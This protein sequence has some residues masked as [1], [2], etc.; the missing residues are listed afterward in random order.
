[1]KSF[2]KK[3]NYLLKRT[4][5]VILLCC[6]VLLAAVS[7]ILLLS[8]GQTTETVGT[9]YTPPAAG[10]ETAG[11]FTTAPVQTPP[12][13]AGTPFPQQTEGIQTSGPS[14]TPP[15][16]APEETQIAPTAVPASPTVPPQNSENFDYSVLNGKDTT[17]NYLYLSPDSGFAVPAQAAAWMEQYRFIAK[18]NPTEKTVYLTFNIDVEYGFT[19]YLLDQLKAEGIKATFFASGDY[20]ADPDNAEIIKRIISEGHLLASHGNRHA[21]YT[22][23]EP[24]QVVQYISQVEKRYEKAFGQRRA[25]SYYRPPYGYYSERDLCIATELGVTT[26]LFSYAYQDY[27]DKLHGHDYVVGELISNLH[28][29]AIYQ[30]HTKTGE[31]AE[32]LPDFVR[33]AAALG[34]RFGRVDEIR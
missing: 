1:M 25:I 5:Y 10:S 23:L 34:Y 14:K 27:T 22:S 20:I 18:G 9:V 26:V 8:R 24:Q 13:T 33:Q 17:R 30:L 11:A 28:N 16:A 15:T 19:L 2:F 12:L 32:A 31:N 7:V 4:L 3:T 29:G 21:L 6:M